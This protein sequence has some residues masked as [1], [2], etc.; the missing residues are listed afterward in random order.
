MVS[1]THTQ[2]QELS[3]SKLLCAAQLLS[4]RSAQSELTDVN[5]V[6]KSIAIG[7]AS[8]SD[9]VSEIFL[10]RFLRSSTSG[11]LPVGFI[12]I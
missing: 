9:T 2:K 7:F 3:G 6:G 10:F 5:F 8:R 12:G 11:H 4:R 1:H